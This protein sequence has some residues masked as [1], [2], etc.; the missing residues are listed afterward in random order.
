MLFFCTSRDKKVCWSSIFNTYCP[1]N[2]FCHFNNTRIMHYWKGISSPSKDLTIP[3]NLENANL[4]LLT[5]KQEFLLI[6]IQL[7][8]ALHNG[9]LANHFIIASSLVSSIFSRRFMSLQ[10]KCLMNFAILFSRNLPSK[11]KIYY[12]NCCITKDCF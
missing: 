6:L 10:I 11:F 1:S 2:D 8:L 12:P 7:R 4:R 9:D 5:L 3:G